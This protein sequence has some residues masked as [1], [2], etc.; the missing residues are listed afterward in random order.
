MS[1][2]VLWVPSNDFP[3]M[4]GAYLPDADATRRGFTANIAAVPRAQLTSDSGRD[5]P[6][7]FAFDRHALNWRGFAYRNVDRVVAQHGRNFADSARA[8]AALEFGN[9][10]PRARNR[11]SDA[12]SYYAM[13]LV[14]SF[15]EPIRRTQVPNTLLAAIPVKDVD[16][17]K[18]VVKL[19]FL[20][21]A[22]SVELRTAGKTT[23][24]LASH[25]VSEGY[26]EMFVF[27]TGYRGGDWRERQIE[28]NLSFSSDGEKAQACMD[29]LENYASWTWLKTGETGLDAW[30]L[31]NLP[32]GNQTSPHTY[33]TTA[34]DTVYAD[35]MGRLYALKHLMKG[36]AAKGQ[37]ALMISDRIIH[38]LASY[39]NFGAGGPGP[40]G[41][42][43]VMSLIQAEGYEVQIVQ[44]MQ[45]Y[46][47]DLVDGMI[48]YVR[49]AN[50][51]QH[52]VGMKPGPADTYTVG[53]A[54][55]T[56]MAMISGG[57]VC[58]DANSCLIFKI[59][60]ANVTTAG[61]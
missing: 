31:A 53:G 29:A 60:V 24:P 51:L 47:G 7:G 35:F 39:T 36:T 2:M 4:P 8:R 45:D 9:V 46:G 13:E 41:R 58:P 16:P 38:H 43:F 42:A 5:L 50:G 19:D 6:A 54:T 1:I 34:A 22:A 28:R 17:S 3:V 27:H 14:Q 49:H 12:T 52:L 55:I 21:T 37:L 26:R 23:V 25:S 10:A 57:L 11:F 30:S 15:G 44:E 20:N 32:V 61:A 18:P 33:G 40:A 59:P 56:E 48:P